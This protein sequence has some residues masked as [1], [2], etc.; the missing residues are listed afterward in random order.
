MSWV[1]CL[2]KALCRNEVDRSEESKTLT[3]G[4][5]PR[6]NRCIF[7][8]DQRN[9]QPTSGHR[10]RRTWPHAKGHREGMVLGGEK[11]WSDV[12]LCQRT[13]NRDGVS[14]LSLREAH[15]DAVLSMHRGMWW[16]SVLEADVG[17]QLFHQVSGLGSRRAGGDRA[18]TAWKSWIWGQRQLAFFKILPTPRTVQRCLYYLNLTIIL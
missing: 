7:P 6:R 18:S 16:E 5:T 9:S 13:E 12:C 4:R 14:G 15:V 2:R 8:C 10:R 3:L 17:T 11:Q 1:L